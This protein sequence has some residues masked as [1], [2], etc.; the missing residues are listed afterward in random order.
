MY[1]PPRA[2]PDNALIEYLIHTMEEL[3]TRFSSAKEIISG[4][5]N[6]LNTEE[7]QEKLRLKQAKNFLTHENNIV[8]L[9]LA[10]L[11]DSYLSPLATSSCATQQ[12][13]DSS[14]GPLPNDLIPHTPSHQDLQ[15]R[16]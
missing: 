14:L 13:F 10:D 8:D 2:T 15:V 16:Y 1:D 9:I 3:Q 12:T 7:L 4:A 6:Q 5:F 11:G